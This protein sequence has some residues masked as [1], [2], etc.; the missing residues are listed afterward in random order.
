MI[1]HVKIRLFRVKRDALHRGL[2]KQ[3]AGIR[4]KRGPFTF[5]FFFFE[6]LLLPYFSAPE[7]FNT[8]LN[9]EMFISG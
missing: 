6:N 1:V 7:H 4:L 8:R 5:R 9:S 3:K 2:W